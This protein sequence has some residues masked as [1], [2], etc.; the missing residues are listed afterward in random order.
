MSLAL[1]YADL[2]KYVG[3]HAGYG[4]DP[5]S[6]T[7][8]WDAEKVRNVDRAINDGYRMFLFNDKNHS[9]SFLRPVS[10]M[11]TVNTIAV[12]ALPADFGHHAGDITIVD[13]SVPYDS[14]PW[15]GEG[16]LRG[17]RSAG[18]SSSGVPQMAAARPLR[19]G[20]GPQ[21]WEVEFY[22]TPDAAYALEIP[23]TVG[24]PQALSTSNPYPYG[25]AMHSQ[26]LK[27]ACLAAWER[28]FDDEQGVQFAEFQRQLAASI[29][30]DSRTRGN[31]LGRYRDESGPTSRHGRERHQSVHTVT[32]NDV[33][34]T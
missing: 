13:S 32:V 16:H 25:G 34:P 31:Y 20:G 17:V 1:A 2:Q 24:D 8:P 10:A 11:A 33:E 3:I 15:V 23:Y 12:Y 7:A 19:G 21:R 26:A 5:E 29:S 18:P 27:A 22:P 14:I 9:W 6:E 30:A 28:S 4:D